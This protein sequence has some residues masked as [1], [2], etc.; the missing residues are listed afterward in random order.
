MPPKELKLSRGLSSFDCQDHFAIL[1]VPLG[2]DGKVI[3]KRYL[4]IA[5][6]LHPDSADLSINRDQ[7][8]MVLSRLVNPA[9]EFLSQDKNLEEYFLLLRLVGQRS[10]QNRAKVS[11]VSEAAL[12]LLR[13]PE[14]DPSYQAAVEALSHRQLE[15]F[16]N[17]LAI[18]EDLSELNLVYL[19]RREEP[20]RE[21]S[22]PSPAP[23]VRPKVVP[24]PPPE[25]RAVV[26][27][28]DV[29]VQHQ[30]PPEEM[31]EVNIALIE[32]YCR[33]AEEL[34][35]K[36]CYVEA[37]RELRE[38]VEGNNPIDPTNG[39]VLTLIGDVYRQHLNTPAMARAYYT[40]ALKSDPNNKEA[41]AGLNEIQKVRP[42]KSTPS[43]AKPSQTSSGKKFSLF[44]FLSRNK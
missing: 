1:G 24:P 33:R 26:S 11:P 21:P 18:T 8:S 41:R 4:K 12:T 10:A 40:K 43:K 15:S 16:E 44:G 7:A 34:I 29:P 23:P 42:A 28:T 27:K 9:Y 14:I 20:A 37:V 19:M 17:Y 22:K 38:V 13:A 6:R 32:Q 31:L 2:A 30:P 5:R 39:K 3:R 25:D 36:A 35:R